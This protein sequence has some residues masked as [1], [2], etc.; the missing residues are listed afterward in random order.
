MSV[1]IK[2]HRSEDRL[3]EMKD[4]ITCWLRIAIV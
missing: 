2:T 4:P 3:V 1:L